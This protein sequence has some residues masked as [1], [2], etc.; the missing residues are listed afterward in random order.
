MTSWPNDRGPWE[1][2]FQVRGAGDGPEHLVGLVALDPALA[3]VHGYEAVE[4]RHGQADGHCGIVAELDHVLRRAAVGAVVVAE[5]L[6]TVR[7]HLGQVDAVVVEVDA[8]AS[9]VDER[10]AVVALEVDA[11]AA[12]DQLRDDGSG[13]VVRNIQSIPRYMPSYG[14][15]FS[16]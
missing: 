7:Y 12:D 5:D 2:C 8:S 16:S 15:T 11:V 14:V 10:L 13:L 3:A 9:A 1:T 6:V 4:A